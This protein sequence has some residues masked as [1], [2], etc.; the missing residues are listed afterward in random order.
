MIKLHNEQYNKVI[1]ALLPVEINTLFAQAVVKQKAPGSVFVDNELSPKTFYISHSYGMSL[2]FGDVNNEGFNSELKGYILNSKKQRTKVEWLQAYPEA[3]NHEISKLCGSSMI[4]SASLESN[5]AIPDNIDKLVKCTRVNFK[6]DY[7][8]Y[9]KSKDV[10]LKLNE[11]LSDSGLID[12]SGTKEDTF[13]NMQG[14]VIPRFFWSSPE[15]FK[16]VGAGFT[17]YYNGEP[18]STAFS[19]FVEEKKLEIGIE[20]SEKFR[21][22]GFAIL[23]CCALIDYCLERGLEPV[24]A[25]RLENTGSYQLAQKLG[26]VPYL[27]IPYYRLPV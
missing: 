16:R 22:K 4:E 11:P 26:F 1:D 19:A 12:I 23:V 25:C 3:W 20:T 21:G 18:A 17:L 27:N 6:F 10:L 9:N 8:F 7:D 14:S 24:W 13:L 15:I 2:L 5:S